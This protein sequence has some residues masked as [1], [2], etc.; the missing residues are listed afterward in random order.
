M[1]PIHGI[2]VLT[3]DPV[4]LLPAV[5]LPLL[6]WLLQRYATDLGVLAR[7]RLVRLAT[8]ACAAVVGLLTWQALRGLPLLRPDA[9]VL[10]ATGLG[11]G[12]VTVAVIVARDRR[13]A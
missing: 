9:A 5:L 13:A 6:A 10:S 4:R 7:V 11:A 3:D 2:W 8:V 12:L 1:T